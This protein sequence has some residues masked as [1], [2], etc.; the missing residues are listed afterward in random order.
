VRLFSRLR[1]GFRT[2]AQRWTL[3]AL[4]GA[5]V[6]TACETVMPLTADSIQISELARWA[7]PAG[8]QVS[9]TIVES[10]RPGEGNEGKETI[11]REAALRSAAAEVLYRYFPIA[12]PLSAGGEQHAVVAIRGQWNPA[13]T[14]LR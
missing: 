12:I 13:P 2:V 10:R 4:A 3:L 7:V 9:Y 14:R 6:S 8:F 11:R 5:L 1:T